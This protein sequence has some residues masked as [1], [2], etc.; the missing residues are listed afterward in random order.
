MQIKMQAVLAQL[1]LEEAV[2]LFVRQE[3]PAAADQ[4]I[5]VTFE[6]DKDG[7]LTALAVVDNAVGG[8]EPAGQKP[9]TTGRGKK[10]AAAAA[11]VAADVKEDEIEQTENQVES[12]EVAEAG[13]QTAAAA[14]GPDNTPPFDVDETKTAQPNE[15]QASAPLKIF[16]DLTSSAAPSTP[17]PATD[18]AVAAKSL[19]ANLTKPTQ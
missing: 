3:F 12:T 13:E 19:F 2:R 7:N 15:V 1:E 4:N 5:T 16:P 8:A 17:K 18:P 11:T 14:G 9:K 10:A 6:D